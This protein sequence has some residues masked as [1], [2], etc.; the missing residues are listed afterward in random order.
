[1]TE[2]KQK[3]ISREFLVEKKKR[4]RTKSIAPFTIQNKKQNLQERERDD[5]KTNKK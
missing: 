1:L 2:T 5:L 3:L 4:S